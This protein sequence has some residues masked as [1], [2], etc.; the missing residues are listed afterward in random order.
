MY[1]TAPQVE[2]QNPS[3][4]KIVEK[5]YKLYRDKPTDFTDVVDFLNLDK[6]TPENLVRVVESAPVECEGFELPPG[7]KVYSLKG[8]EGTYP[9]L[10]RKDNTRNKTQQHT[11]TTTT[12]HTTNYNYNNQ[13]HP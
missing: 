6:N 4:F 13:T 5:K 10:A 7:A 9:H 1:A 11:T 8:H 3:A 2:G 12:H